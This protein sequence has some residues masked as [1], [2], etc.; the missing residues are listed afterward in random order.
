MDV[1]EEMEK[2]EDIWKME[3]G[4]NSSFAGSESET[5]RKRELLWWGWK[6][7]IEGQGGTWEERN[8]TE[9]PLGRMQATKVAEQRGEEVEG[10]ENAELLAAN[11]KGNSADS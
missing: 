1:G 7:G 4:R 2:Q 11:E 6:S 3:W 9:E 5:I 8:S 10:V